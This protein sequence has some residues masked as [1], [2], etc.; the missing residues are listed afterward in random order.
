MFGRTII[1]PP[2]YNLARASQE[3]A[4][5]DLAPCPEHREGHLRLAEIFEERVSAW[6]A[7]EFEAMLILD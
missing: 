2:E 3:R 6:R 5:A 4:K 7:L 1:L